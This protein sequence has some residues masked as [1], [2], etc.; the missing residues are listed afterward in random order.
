MLCH[1]LFTYIHTPCALPSLPRLAMPAH[2]STCTLT[3]QERL[4]NNEA[5]A[6]QQQRRTEAPGDG[7]AERAG[8]GAGGRG[9]GGRGIGGRGHDADLDAAPAAKPLSRKV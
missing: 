5:R 4:S 8:R 9:G 1:L 3:P 2:S 6:R 7:R